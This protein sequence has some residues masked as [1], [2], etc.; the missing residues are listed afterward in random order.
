[1]TAGVLS[2]V[3]LANAARAPPRN[4]DSLGACPVFLLADRAVT[5]TEG[6]AAIADSR[7]AADSGTLVVAAR[8]FA[9]RRSSAM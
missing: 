5:R 8:A 6:Q 2:A 4:L 1:M 3:A 7:N 9:G